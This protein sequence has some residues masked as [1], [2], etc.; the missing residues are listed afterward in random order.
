MRKIKIGF[1][2]PQTTVDMRN[3]YLIDCIP[4]EQKWNL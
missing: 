4:G 1:N 3:N 2:A